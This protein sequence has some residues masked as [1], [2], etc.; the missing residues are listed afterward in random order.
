ML[1][2]LPKQLLKGFVLIAFL[3]IFLPGYSLDA[4]EPASSLGD[5][6][7]KN[8]S[9]T[10]TPDILPVDKAF[11]FGFVPDGARMRLFWQIMPGYYLYREKFG[12]TVG[13][14]DLVV[15]LHA[16]TPRDDE[17]FGRVEVYDGLLEI[18]MPPMPIGTEIEVR[19]QGCAEQGYCYPPQKRWVIVAK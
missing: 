15:E 4:G 2:K 10:G 7:F 17:V 12:F 16:G 11:R 5:S 1:R 19:Y 14:E 9:L 8:R 6:S 13:K 3:G 18:S